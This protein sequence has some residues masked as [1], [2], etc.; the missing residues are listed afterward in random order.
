[1]AS[2][3]DTDRIGDWA[4]E[5]VERLVQAGIISGR[6]DGTIF[7]PKTGTTRAQMAKMLDEYLKFVNFSN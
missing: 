7:D 6:E 4:K 2:F 5:D 3:D 1:M